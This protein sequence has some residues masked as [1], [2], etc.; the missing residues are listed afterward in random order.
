MSS[1]LKTENYELPIFEPDDRPSWLGDW[2]ES[3]ETIDTALGAVSDNASDALSEATQA[4]QESEVAYNNSVN[5]KREAVEANQKAD[6]LS[7][8]INDA[9][10]KS[11]Q[12]TLEATNAMVIASGVDGKATEALENSQTAIDKSGQNE[13][14]IRE[15]DSAKA[16][17]KLLY[18]D[19]TNIRENK[20]G[21]ILT[22]SDIYSLISNP[23]IH[24]TVNYADGNVLIPTFWVGS[25]IEFSNTL[26]IGSE[27]YVCRLIINNDNQIKYEEVIIN[28]EEEVNNVKALALQA[29]ENVDAL[30]DTV[31]S[32]T[33]RIVALENSGGGGSNFE[34]LN[35]GTI[36]ATKTITLSKETDPSKYIVLLNSGLAH[37]SVPD[38]YGLWGNG[39]YIANKTN[40]SVQIVIDKR[41]DGH[42]T[43]SYEIV[44]IAD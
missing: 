39:C 15:L 12:A 16:E 4:K 17:L 2:N 29:N 36:S 37:T 26:I 13:D 9:V 8:A 32:N 28:T 11:E 10:S 43:C 6:G 41:S 25:A 21:T 38:S 3:M 18:F 19:G 22:Y 33:A 20:G 34:V 23:I 44:K 7:G 5:A 30:S 40:T 31:E 24:L 35:F 42:V 14:D 1:S 27:C